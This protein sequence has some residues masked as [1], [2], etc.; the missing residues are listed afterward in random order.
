MGRQK[1]DEPRHPEKRRIEHVGVVGAQHEI[2]PLSLMRPDT[3]ITDAP[4][5]TEPDPLRPLELDDEPPQVNV[6]GKALLLPAGDEDPITDWRG[7]VQPD[8]TRA[9][10]VMP[11]NG[12]HIRNVIGAERILAASTIAVAK[13]YDNRLASTSG[14][15]EGQEL[16]EVLRRSRITL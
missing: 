12:M 9:P 1:G 7:I 16:D 14:K 13:A 5:G 15:I 4:A 11:P 3:P 8:G 10:F 6:I 2:V